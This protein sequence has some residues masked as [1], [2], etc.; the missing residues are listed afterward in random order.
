MSHL[1]KALDR[2]NDFA[3]RSLNMSRSIAEKSATMSAAIADVI[4]GG[5]ATQRE[6]IATAQAQYN[7]NRGWVFSCVDLIAQRI[8]GQQIH[9]ASE[10]ATP[11]GPP[12]QKAFG[13]DLEPLDS[14]PLLDLINA[15][16]ALMSGA[17]LIYS[18]VASL[19][20]CGRA[21]WWIIDKDGAKSILP[22]PASWIEKTDVDH[23]KWTLRLPNSAKT[24]DVPGSECVY[25]YR[26]DPGNPWGHI[27]PLSAIAEAVTTDAKI[28]DAQWRV[29][30]QGIWPASAV[31]VGKQPLPPGQSGQP[32]R[33][34][35]TPE[36]RKQIIVAIETAYRGSEKLGKPLI[37]DGMIEKVERLSLTPDELAFL[38]SAKLTKS[39]ILQGY[40]VSPILLGEVEGANRASA[41]IADQN[42][43][44]GKV[45]PLISL[46][47]E[48]LT[49][50]LCPMFASDG[51]RLKAWIEPARARDD[52]MQL[53]RW[54][55]AAAREFVT[56]D[57]FRRH[58]LNLPPREPE[59]KD[60][61]TQNVQ[62]AALNG[63]QISSL[64]QIAQLVGEGAINH[65]AARAIIA[66]SFPLLSDEKI[67]AIVDSLD[68]TDVTHA[69]AV[70]ELAK[71]L[72]PYTLKRLT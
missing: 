18:T 21:L 40:H 22:V 7:H 69:P 58:V 10:R 44:S 24:I 51:E 54:Q 45:N 52:E 56:P 9:L 8:A 19:E 16:N 62:A 70:A 20:L 57:E 37:L 31:I 48:G 23:S 13:D 66:A 27:S 11:A 68:V 25:F 36:Q 61:S 15:P 65:D 17:A 33:P 5:E 46:I 35:L 72:N 4:G 47:S 12:T 42:F 49:R 41:A 38:D 71:R 32:M 39:K 1:A 59:E 2:S 64:V 28:S 55:Y 3:T 29:F 67:D 63:A 43:V 14:H 50:F 30:S 60:S 6:S 34:M 26:P 53:R